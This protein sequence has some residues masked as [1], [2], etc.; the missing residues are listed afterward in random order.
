[1][2][3]CSGHCVVWMLCV[4]VG[5]FVGVGRVVVVWFVMLLGVW[6]NLLFLIV[7]ALQWADG[8]F[9]WCVVGV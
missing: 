7:N 3:F 6:D 1:M 8:V 9:R 2:L 5:T 4:G